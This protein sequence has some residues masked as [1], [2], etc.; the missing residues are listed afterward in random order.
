MNSQAKNLLD[1]SCVYLNVFFNNK[2]LNK[3]PIDILTDARNKYF[4]SRGK[5]I[6]D[7]VCFTAE[8]L[9]Y[10]Y[11]YQIDPKGKL[12]WKATING[13]VTEDIATEPAGYII[14]YRA[15]NNTVVKKMYFNHSHIWQKTEYF[16][17][18]TAQPEI[19]LMPWL[20]DERAAIA[21]YDS[22]SSF[23]QILYALPAIDNNTLLQKAVAACQPEVVATVGNS[24]YYFGDDQTEELWLNVLGSHKTDTATTQP[25]PSLKQYFNVMALRENTSYKNLADTTEIFGEIKPAQPIQQPASKINPAVNMEADYSETVLTVQESQTTEQ[26]AAVQVLPIVPNPVVPSPVVTNLPAQAPAIPNVQPAKPK[27]KAGDNT[28]ELTADKSVM[29][30]Q[31]EKGLYFGELDTANNRSG[32]GRTQTLKGKTVYDGEY[33]NDMKNG[34]GVSYFKT[35]RVSYVG[36]YSDDKCNGFGIEFRA[37]DGSVTVADYAENSKEFVHARFDKNG[38]LIFAGNRFENQQSGIVFSPE[39]G[40]MFIAKY[41]NG[42]PL[43]FG[44][45][46][47]ADGILVYTGEYKNGNKDG[48]GTLF[49]SDGSVRYTGEFKRNLYSGNGVLIL[50]NTDVYTGEFLAGQPNGTGELKTANGQLIYSGQWKKGLY[51]GDGR[52]YNADGTYTEAKFQNGVAKG[53]LVVYDKNGMI[54]YNGV[55]VDNKPDGSGICYENGQKVYDGQLSEGVKSGTG[56]LYSN[57]ECVYMG[58]FENDVF[59]GF[60]IRYNSGKTEYC[61]MWSNNLYHGAGLLTIDE[62]TSMAGNFTNGVP[63]GRINIIRNGILVSECIYVNGEC[64]YMREYSPDGL[65]VVYDGNIKG[66]L[67]EGMGCT[68]TEYG[69]KL[70]EGI[71]KNGEPLK[72]MKVSTREIEP[73]EYVPKLK[74]TDYEKFRNSREFVVEQPMING[75]YSGQLNN[76]VPDGKGTILYIDHRYTGCFSNGVAC[77]SGVVYFGDGTVVSGIFADKPLVNTQAVEFANVVYH[78]IKNQ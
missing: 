22:T 18:N 70:F 1:K 5:K 73:L 16:N 23:P 45:I 69:E 68:F 25:K 56:R 44:T 59:S 32:Y 6:K 42:E 31:K 53:K 36:N 63:N 58:S 48:K 75:V 72:S 64:E 30:S 66:N 2:E 60:G 8:G 14:L 47:S 10:S 50:D 37:T 15:S 74:D 24:T 11:V 39:N 54:K 65:S 76:G 61:G 7:K 13:V 9:K 40:E 21:M 34:F 3:A 28:T 41:V 77:G 62:Y 17:Q 43:Q 52:L 12:K 27:K 67:R 29:L 33:K 49:N 19:C 20:N 78:L 71:F 38:K 57:G 51:N 26:P 35:G 55:V 46:I 4:V